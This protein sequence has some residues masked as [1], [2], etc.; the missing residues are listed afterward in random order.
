MIAEEILIKY[1]AVLKPYTKNEMIFFKGDPALYYHQVKS[2][3]IKMN[4]YNEEGKEFVQGIFSAGRS[5]G[6]PP[7]FGDFTYPANSVSMGQSE[8]WRLSKQYFYQLLKENPEIHLQFTEVMADRLYYKAIMVS[9][10]SS[11]SPD[12]RI[13]VLID[14]LKQHIHKIEGRFQFEVNL[15]RQQIADLTGLRVET[16]IRTI[17]KL[18]K[19]GD[20]KISNKKVFR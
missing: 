5:F 3:E 14:Y 10:I 17:K 6:E 15:T 9:E 4:N 1:G 20:L 19:K 7:L 16:V 11:Q 2:G 12:H 18:E 13:L 8:V